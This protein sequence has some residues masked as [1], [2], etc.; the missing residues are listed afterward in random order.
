LLRGSSSDRLEP[1]LTERRKQMTL[2]YKELKILKAALMYKELP[3]RYK[4]DHIPLLKK[5]ISLLVSNN[6]A[7]NNEVILK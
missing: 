3:K 4:R 1:R 5:L 7:L 2:N 6:G